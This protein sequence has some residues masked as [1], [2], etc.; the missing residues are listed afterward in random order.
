MPAECP[1]SS[2]SPSISDTRRE[3]A[4][5]RGRAVAELSAAQHGVVSLAQLRDVG[6]GDSAVRERIACARLVRIH[7]AVYA[8]GH[9]PLSLNGRWMAAV[10]ACGPG[11]ALC[12]HSAAAALG[13]IE[14][15]RGPEVTSPGRCGKARH[16]ITVR[17]RS[18]LLPRDR[19]TV[20]GIPCTSVGRTLLDLAAVMHPQRMAEICERAERQATFTSRRF[21]TC[22]A[23]ARGSVGFADFAL[24]SSSSGRPSRPPAAS[25]SGASW[26]SAPGP[27]CPGH[28]SMPGSSYRA[29]DWR[30]ISRGRTLDSWWR[31]TAPP[32]TRARWPSSVTGPAI[33][34]SCSPAGGCCG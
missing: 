32:T 14:R 1:N 10:L 27:A 20:D 33:A 16:A 31:P 30:P 29:A 24:R 17:Q 18:L 21:G 23:D 2:D 5:R 11:A 34:S 3:V 25:S 26:G 13:L 12:G 19:T 22:W 6:L 4:I 8:T 9:A 7:E 28:G 15:D